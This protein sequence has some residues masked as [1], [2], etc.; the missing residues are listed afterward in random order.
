MRIAMI[1]MAATLMSAPAFAAPGPWQWQPLD[2]A[3]M[4]PMSG[5][6]LSSHVG[7]WVYAADGSVVGS[8]QS[9]NGD[10]ASLHVSAFFKPGDQPLTVPTQ[11]LGVIHGKLVVHDTSFAQLA[12]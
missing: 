2:M 1:V 5:H 3:D 4:Q 6:Q 12:Q 9:I 11:D 7:G 8:L 10:Q